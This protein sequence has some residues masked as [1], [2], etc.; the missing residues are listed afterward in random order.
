MVLD[1][2]QDGGLIQICCYNLPWYV[3]PICKVNNFTSFKNN[4]AYVGQ[5][6]ILNLFHTEHETADICV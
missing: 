5:F 1:S 3:S 4:K 2:S 6:N